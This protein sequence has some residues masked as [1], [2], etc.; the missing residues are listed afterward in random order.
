MADQDLPSITKFMNEQS[1]ALLLMENVS[2][3]VEGQ[4]GIEEATSQITQSVAERAERNIVGGNNEL[5]YI[6]SL[7]QN[8]T[9]SKDAN[10]LTALQAIY[11]DVQT[12][13]SQVN[14]TDGTGLQTLSTD[15]TTTTQASQ[16]LITDFGAAVLEVMNTTTSLIQK[17]G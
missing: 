16:Q 10:Q 9:G 1:P 14:N 2:K 7:M 17:M 15:L 8:L 3:E 12:S 6:S 5:T 13:T 4:M 11:Q